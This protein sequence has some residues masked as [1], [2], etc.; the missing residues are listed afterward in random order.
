MV[1]DPG[2]YRGHQHHRQ[3]CLPAIVDDADFRIQQR[4]ATESAVNLIVQAVKLQKHHADSGLGQMFGVAILIGKPQ[5][6][7]RHWHCS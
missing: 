2:S 1:I 4:C 5:T 7:G 6:V 3:T